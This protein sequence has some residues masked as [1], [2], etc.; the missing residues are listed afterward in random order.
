MLIFKKESDIIFQVNN[1][2]RKEKKCF[3]HVFNF[4]RYNTAIRMQLPLSVYGFDKFMTLIQ[5]I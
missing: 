5:A 1:L 3:S 4:Q 2:V